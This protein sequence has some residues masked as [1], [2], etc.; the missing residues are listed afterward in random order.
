MRLVRHR[1]T[2]DGPLA[3]TMKQ[4]DPLDRP[5]TTTTIQYTTQL[6]V[7]SEPLEQTTI[8]MTLQPQGQSLMTKANEASQ[9]RHEKLIA[10]IFA[11]VG[12]LEQHVPSEADQNEVQDTAEAVSTRNASLEQQDHMLANLRNLRREVSRL[13]SYRH[14]LICGIEEAKQEVSSDLQAEKFELAIG[15]AALNRRLRRTE[16]EYEENQ[17]LRERNEWLSQQ[18]SLQKE[19]FEQSLLAE[20]KKYAKDLQSCEGRQ[21]R[22]S[23]QLREKNEQQRHDQLSAEQDFKELM[24]SA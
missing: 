23:T 18:L 4:N 20:R 12:E 19:M 16:E 17:R 9:T 11:Q 1:Y 24:A 22:Y 6:I 2:Q 7:T 14:E 15:M 8:I 13:Q 5:H 10:D 3:F 21:Q